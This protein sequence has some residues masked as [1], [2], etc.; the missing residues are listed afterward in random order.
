MCPRDI[1]LLPPTLLVQNIK[2]C[3]KFTAVQVVRVADVIVAEA[4]D[5]VVVEW[6]EVATDAAVVLETSV[7]CL[8]YLT[9][10][11]AAGDL[12]HFQL[13]SS[14]SGEMPCGEII[15]SSP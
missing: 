4:A 8:R 14:S 7:W 13:P 12:G 2:T 1:T 10:T 6:L 5:A 3:Y 9:S 11:A 15:A